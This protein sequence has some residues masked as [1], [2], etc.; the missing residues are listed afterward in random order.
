MDTPSDRPAP[1]P[2]QPVDEIERHIQWSGGAVLAFLAIMAGFLALAL[3]SLR[4]L[5]PPLSGLPEDP[6]AQVAAR[7]LAG[8]A[9]V[10]TPG[11]RMHAAVLGGEAGAFTPPP[12]DSARLAMATR[13]LSS[14]DSHRAPDPRRVAALAAIELVR[15]NAAQ[16]ARLYR[17]LTTRTRN[18]G[19]VHLG[20]ALAL[21]LRA[22]DGAEEMNARGLR[23][24][25]IAQC[26][27]VRPDDPAYAAAAYDRA[28]LAARVGRAGEARSLAR[29]YLERY[30]HGEWS[31]RLRAEL[32]L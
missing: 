28:I 20:Y 9:R 13:L 18:Y 4:P 19:E 24:Q 6:D 11:L 30:P 26:A 8:R 2:A 7:L 16:A 31:N 15:G 14:G 32:G 25:A 21:A 5:P 1:V 22:E 29:L 17:P 10:A 23:L 12:A 3:F 27:A